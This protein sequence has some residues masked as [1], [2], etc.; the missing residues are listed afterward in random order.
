METPSAEEKNKNTMAMRVE[1]P[2]GNRKL[3]VD[4][5][6]SPYKTLRYVC[7]VILC[8]YA[9]METSSSQWNLRD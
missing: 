2:R 3:N 6:K 1:L 7:S 4:H 8:K 9:L 5:L